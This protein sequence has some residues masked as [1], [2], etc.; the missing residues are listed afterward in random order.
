MS[1]N[2]FARVCTTHII[3]NFL[4]LVLRK[5]IAIV[6]T[7]DGMIHIILTSVGTMENHGEI[8]YNT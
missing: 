7:T 2:I 5:S 3:L 1:D 4:S 8:I 6:H